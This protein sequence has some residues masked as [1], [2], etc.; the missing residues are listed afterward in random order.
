MRG[1]LPH[2]TQA[3]VQDRVRVQAVCDPAPGRA[4]AAAARFAIPH[5]FSSIEE[6]LEHGDVDA[7]TIVSPIGLHHEHGRLSL[8]AGKHVHFNK[9]MTTTVAEAT[10]LIDLAREQ[11]LRVV[12]SPGEVL[13]PH[14]ARIRELIA[15]GAIG[16]LVW[17]ICGAS[18][19]TYHEDESER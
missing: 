2:L 6:L 1:I 7:V 8:L 11:D 4:E 9:T 12:A 13:R 14:N 10:E 3:D 16:K 18:S 5:T 19:G 15:E 17:A